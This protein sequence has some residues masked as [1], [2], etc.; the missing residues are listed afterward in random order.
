MARPRS[1][2]GTGSTLRVHAD[3]T[4]LIRALEGL[5]SHVAPRAVTF[6]LNG[7]GMLAERKVKKS[8]RQYIDNPTAFT[9]SAIELTTAGLRDFERRR[10]KGRKADVSAKIKVRNDG[11][12][13]RS[14]YFKFLMGERSIRLPNDVGPGLTHI[15][16]PIWRNLRRFE[17]GIRPVGGTNGGLPRNTLNRLLREAYGMGS[18]K[19]GARMEGTS[20]FVGN[21]NRRMGFGI[22]V[23]PRRAWNRLGKTMVHQDSP[24]MLV[25][26]ADRAKYKAFFLGPWARAVTDAYETLPARLE[27][28]LNREL[29]YAIRKGKL[30]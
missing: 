21:P 19:R 30:S 27:F 14:A 3:I 23:R 28:E 22:W 10:Y 4:P 2:P 29:G 25:R 17:P 13:D 20:L 11:K 9:K 1:R 16:I 18:K 12:N 7:I 24:H 5:G 15:Y 26:L 6:A 8:I